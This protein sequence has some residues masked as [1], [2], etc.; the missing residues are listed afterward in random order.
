MA[1]RRYLIPLMALMMLMIVGATATAP[2]ALSRAS[3]AGEGETETRLA[4]WAGQAS[5]TAT[6]RAGGA[7]ECPRAC[8]RYRTCA[9]AQACL[10]RGH[11]RLDR[12]R[13]GVPCEQ[14]C[15]GG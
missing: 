14:I 4:A 11:T 9:Q 12:D 5:A 13:D 6:P 3:V 2:P 10:R 7:F 15:T 1:F 8:A